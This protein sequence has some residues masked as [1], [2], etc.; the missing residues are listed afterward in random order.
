MQQKG[1]DT[2]GEMH[3]SNGQNA[4]EVWTKDSTGDDICPFKTQEAELLTVE[5]TL[6]HHHRCQAFVLYQHVFDQK[7]I[8]MSSLL[9]LLFI[10]LA[11]SLGCTHQR[12]QAHQS[13]D[14]RLTCQELQ[15]DMVRAEAAA[16]DVE[17]KTGFSGRNVGLALVFWPGIIVNEVQGSKAIDAAHMRLTRL[18]ELYAQQNCATPPKE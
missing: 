16:R 11:F 12:I 10:L 13:T 18:N 5:K 4:P 15:M 14:L 3:D 1:G 2:Y 8:S 17:N 7:G 9:C 6:S